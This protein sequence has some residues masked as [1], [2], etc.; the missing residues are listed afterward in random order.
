M[1]EIKIQIDNI[2]YDS[3]A[4]TLLPL[5][6]DQLACSTDN[7]ML[8]QLFSGRQRLSLSAAKSFIS[9]LPKEKKDELVVKYMNSN[10][11]QLSQKLMQ[12]AADN[13]IRLNIKN[14]EVENR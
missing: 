6:A 8:K 12:F 10:K 13:K 4:D 14:I 2:D 1:I 5:L 11:V 9:V 7:P 3:A